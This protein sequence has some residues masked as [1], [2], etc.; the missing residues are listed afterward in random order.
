VPDPVILTGISVNRPP[1]VWRY[2]LAVHV[3]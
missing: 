1:L 2:T 3:S